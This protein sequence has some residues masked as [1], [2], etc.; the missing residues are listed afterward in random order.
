MKRLRVATEVSL[1]IAITLAFCAAQ[2]GP[3]EIVHGN[4]S[5]QNASPADPLRDKAASQF[6]S[7]RY[8]RYDLR[9]DDV[10][11]ISFEF[12]P[13][14]NQTV[15]VQPDG[16]VTLRGVGD[17]HV[18]GRTVPE[19]TEAIRTAYGKI[20]K[21]PAIA[22]VLKE[23]DKPYFIAAGQVGRPGKYEL[24]GDTT[25][26]EA[27]AIAGGFNDSAKH[28]QVVLFRRVSR[29]WMEGKVLD[30]KK[31]LNDKSLSEDLHLKHGD[32]VFVPQNRISKFRRYIPVP[33]VGM[34]VNPPL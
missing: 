3:K 11:D 15:T 18:A 27:I 7:Q 32:M 9:A 10:L 4:A 21:D 1:T 6:G 20:L 33:G 25:V 16:Y 12:T 24:R 2:A 14:F 5:V 13:E 34:A 30:V 22:V 31:M 17:V 26:V 29:D 19:L 28:S 8:P 23:F